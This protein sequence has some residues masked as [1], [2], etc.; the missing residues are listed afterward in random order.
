MRRKTGMRRAAAIRKRKYRRAKG[1]TRWGRIFAVLFLLAALVAAFVYYK[2]ESRALNDTAERFMSL[3][4]EDQLEAASLLL[5][6]NAG[7]IDEVSNLISLHR[8]QFNKS[9][10]ARITG[11]GKGHARLAFVR[12]GEEYLSSLEFIRKDGRWLISGLPRFN[13]HYGAYVVKE[14]SGKVE[15]F[16]Q[17][18]ERSYRI[19]GPTGLTRGDVV[20]MVAL[21]DKIIISEKAEPEPVSRILIRSRDQIEGETEG[22]FQL[23]EQ[24]R[25]YRVDPHESSVRQGMESDLIVGRSGV[26]F[27]I[28][29]ERVL[30]VVVDVPY[31]L[32]HIRVVLND[33][34]YANLH[35]GELSLSASTALNLRDQVSGRHYSLPAGRQVRISSDGENLRVV[36]GEGDPLIFPGRIYFS[37]EQDGRVII[38]NLRR[39]GW[40]RESPAY[41]GV[42]EIKPHPRG[43]YMVNELPLEE[44]LYS[45]VPSE[46]PPSFG[47][48]PLKAQ[49]V[50][51]RS[52]AYRSILVS[53][54]GAYGAHVDDSISSQVYNNFREHELTN[55]AIA[56]TR[57]MVPFYRN[58]VVDAR[59][60]STSCG[61]TANFEEVWHDTKTGDFPGTPV[62]YLK[63]RSQV[64]GMVIDMS[65]EESVRQFL[66][67]VYD[68]A[69]DRDSPYFR[70]KIEMSY[71]EIKASIERN[72]A[73]RHESQPA[74]VLTREGE[75]FVSREI[76]DDPVGELLDLRV[77]ER[78]EAGNMLSLEIEGSNG[79]YRIIKEYNI[80]FTLRPVAYLT[81]SP[82]VILEL[83]DDSEFPN[84]PILP[85]AF[86][87]F[88]IH[89]EENGRI[90]KVAIRG[91]G[92]GHGAGMSQYGARGMA[93]KGYN[94]REILEHY[95]PGSELTNIYHP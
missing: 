74:F 21:E 77:V 26:V 72:L 49:A 83:V 76:P 65:G 88:Q 90:E 12:N 20:F 63:F 18:L 35:H 29:E 48:E 44:Y 43:M 1:K 13:I 95:Y 79:T 45:V 40:G 53:A 4:E 66:Q 60:F 19:P 11:I 39:E 25:I 28:Y 24:Y 51:A 16:Y 92:N 94:F 82:P 58:N 56:Q 42:I 41:R 23:H 32:G 89:R 37:P 50:A 78:G 46:M 93:A 33:S 87:F 84:Y 7:G 91:G 9:F 5:H 62:P 10:S 75:E 14:G 52:Y 70:W 71:D 30:A 36:T 55:E 57:G 64:P 81:G 61:V 34:S 17:G 59:F 86:A 68:D 6:R 54:Y 3:V 69:Y 80:R 8:L 47:L 73:S 22:L 85:S 67:S 27:H 15:V 38:H 31:R 2:A